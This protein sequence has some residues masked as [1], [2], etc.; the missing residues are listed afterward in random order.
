MSYKIIL[1]ISLS[2][3]SV[4]CF[5]PQVVSTDQLDDNVNWPQWRGPNR[6]GISNEKGLL[7]EWPESGP[8]EI[9]SVDAVGVGY[10]SIVIN[11]GRIYT[12]GDLQGVEHTI[13]LDTKHGR[14]IWAVQ[15]GPAEQRLAERVAKELKRL[16]INENGQVEELEALGKMRFRDFNR[17]DRATSENAEQTAKERTARIF[18]ALDKDN[19]QK[20]T[21]IE[22]KVFRDEFTQID[23]SG[24]DVDVAALAKQRTLEDFSK[25]DTDSDGKISREESRGSSLERKFNG[26]DVRDMDDPKNEKRKIGDSLLTIKE[27][28]NYYERREA[29]LDGTITAEELNRFYVDRCTNR[30]GIL[31]A[32][33]LRSLYGGYRNGMGDGPRGTPTVD[34]N[35]VYA[36][37]GNG[38]FSCLDAGNG[39]T[40]WHVNLVSDFGGRVPGWGYSE[41]PL[42]E[43]DMVVVTPGG[44]QGTLLALDKNSGELIWQ[45]SDTTQAAHYSSPIVAKI[46]G[47]RQIVQF[48][49]E[50]C[51]GV[52]ASNGKLMWEYKN[53]NNGTANCSTPIVSDDHVFASSAYGTGGGLAKISSD[54]LNQTATEVYFVKS[55]GDHHGGTVKVGDYLYSLGAGRLV[56]M[57]FKTGKIAW[58][59]RSVGKGSLVVADGMLYLLSERQQVGLAEA[60]PEGYRERGRFKIKS[61]GRPSWAHPVVAG[62][63]LY[64]RDQGKLTAYDISQ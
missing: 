36:L 15:P 41:S 10:S 45:S 31:D 48:A 34:G 63:R 14:V 3:S 58:Q 38:D 43:G 42:I 55:M 35:R 26:I 49:R 8:K 11:D 52:N 13:C 33:E 22:A 61:Q 54:G 17:S 56:C 30:D 47:I 64:I 16:D 1:T 32:D 59:D 37:G 20:L 6:D 44:K 24:K 27:L 62:G 53:A 9:W 29:G 23:S 7:K 60:T 4:I 51:F 57:H 19:N 12:Q 50:S 28:E 39:K 40:I 21:F 25:L 18:Q 5:L 2:I 46:G